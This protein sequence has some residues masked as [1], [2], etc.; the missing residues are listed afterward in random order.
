MKKIDAKEAYS[1]ILME[2]G[3]GEFTK[4][5]Y[6][7]DGEILKVFNKEYLT[8][9]KKLEYNDEKKILESEGMYISSEVV[10]P[11][12][13]VYLEGFGYC[14]YTMPFIEG[15][16][17]NQVERNL[18]LEQISDLQYYADMQMKLEKIVRQNPEIVFSDMATFDNIIVDKN[19][20]FNV[21]DF[22]G[23][24]IKKHKTAAL[25]TT[26]G[27]ILYS[28]KYCNNGIYT[29]TLD[30]RTLIMLY[31]LATF[32]IDLK[33]VGQ[34]YPNS[35]EKITLDH[36]FSQI[37][38]NEPSLMHEVWKMLTPDQKEGYIGTVVQKL[39][40]KYKLEVKRN[41]INNYY[42]KRLV[43]K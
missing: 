2:F 21:I 37:G 42:M 11:T 35:R 6:T 4:L 19:N 8:L 26:V 16:T 39:A 12:S 20:K 10:R 29:K 15:K 1:K 32:N 38:L 24:Q 5:F 17:L 27:D 31:F 23:L 14:G 3:S 25:S 43:R 9:L 7:K 30:N 36:V 33:K 34:Y 40:E 13:M 41:P 18:T 28:Q 22:D